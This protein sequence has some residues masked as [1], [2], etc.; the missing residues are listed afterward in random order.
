MKRNH[1]NN[2]DLAPVRETN[3]ESVRPATEPVCGFGRTRMP[4]RS[5]M[6]RMAETPVNSVRT[7]SLVLAQMF[8][9]SREL[10]GLLDCIETC[11]DAEGDA[12][13]PFERYLEYPVWPRDPRT[14]RAVGGPSMSDGMLLGA[15]MRIAVE[16][17]WTEIHYGPYQTVADWLADPPRKGADPAGK[18]RILDAWLAMVRAAGALRR[19]VTAGSLADVPYQLVHRTA[20]AC[21]RAGRARGVLPVLCYVVFR[22]PAAPPADAAAT[23]AFEDAVLGRW[24][25]WLDLSAIEAL[26]VRV[27]VVRTPATRSPEAAARLF[28]A[29]GAGEDPYGLDWNGITLSRAADRQR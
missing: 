22:D 13:E 2:A 5:A 11:C 19:G 4:Y 12:P 18:R 24:T 29:I 8:R 20:S 14:G 21:H 15:H 9:P 25:A 3:P 27:P 10:A 26:V 28:A 1:Q 16:G 17:K 7:S 6:E 23:R